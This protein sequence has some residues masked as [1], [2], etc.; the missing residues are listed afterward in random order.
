MTLVSLKSGKEKKYQKLLRHFINYSNIISGKFLPSLRMKNYYFLNGF[1]KKQK[2]DIVHFPGQYNPLITGPKRICTIHDIQELH[3]P[4]F[5]TPEERRD[6]AITIVDKLKISDL[7]I[8]SYNHV[9]NDLIRYCK[10]PENKILVCLLDMKNLWFK[11]FESL[12][13]KD[14]SSLNLPGKFL[15]YPANTWKHKNHIAL[16]E[17][18]AYLREQENVIINV[19]CTGDK[20]ANFTDTILPRLKELKLEDQ[21]RFLGVVDEETLYSLYQRCVGVVVPTA[22]EAGSFPLIESMIMQVPVIC[23]NVTSLPETI[24]DPQFVFDPYNIPGMAAKIREVYDSEEYRR[25]NIINSK[26][27][28][29]KILNTG[30]LKKVTDS[31]KQLFRKEL[32]G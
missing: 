7:V 10:M 32:A 28:V 11:K 27:N 3:F 1:C 16:L 12:P 8:V 20:N 17:A 15:L 18:L 24:G 21:A 9:K 22:Y 13:A 30:A 6:R 29:E 23:S 26:S 5:F 19:I 31:Y 4:D 2:I 14:I 25:Q